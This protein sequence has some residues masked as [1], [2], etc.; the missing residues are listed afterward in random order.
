[1][2][3]AKVPRK[4]GSSKIMERTFSRIYNV[5][6]KTF[7]GWELTQI[8][9]WLKTMTLQHGVQVKF[10]L[11]FALLGVCDCVNQVGP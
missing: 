2:E 8:W 1:M 11:A 3:M 4:K 9:K 5:L 7:Q 6:F 10:V